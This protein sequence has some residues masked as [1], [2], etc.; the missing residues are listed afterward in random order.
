RPRQPGRR[1]CPS[2]VGRKAVNVV[3]TEPGVGDSPQRRLRR[4]RPRV[5]LEPTAHVREADATDDHT[6]LEVLFH[7]S[8][9]GRN[10]GM[11]ASPCRAN[12][13]WT[14]IP[15]RTSSRGQS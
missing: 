11:Y 4:E 15:I 6:V 9:T 1:I 10:R 2:G 7:R 14:A 12:T 8:P 13:T 3:G 5:A